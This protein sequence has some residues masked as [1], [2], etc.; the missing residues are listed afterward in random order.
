MVR[1]D[2]Y[3]MTS[4]G[5]GRKAFP[6]SLNFLSGGGGFVQKQSHPFY[7]SKAWRKVR[8]MALQRDGGMCVACMDRFRRGEMTKPRRA[9]MVHHIKPLEERPDLALDLN[10]LASNC[11]ACHAREHPEKGG[12]GKARPGK[13]AG[14]GRELVITIK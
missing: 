5:E 9:T 10:N 14:Q 7:R 8:A 12:Q 4:R 1:Y 13:P 11:D 2:K 6:F 3:M